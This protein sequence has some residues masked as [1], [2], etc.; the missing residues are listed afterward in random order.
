MLLLQ[1][2]VAVIQFSPLILQMRKLRLQKLNY[3]KF[4]KLRAVL[5]NVLW[6]CLDLCFQKLI[7]GVFF[8]VLSVTAH[9]RYT[10]HKIDKS[11]K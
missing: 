2:I 9:V 1:Q 10:Y 6:R 5:E 11:I 4:Y 7:L 8:L 3:V